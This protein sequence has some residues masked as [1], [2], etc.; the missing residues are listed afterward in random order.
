MKVLCENYAS[1]VGHPCLRFLVLR[2]LKEVEVSK[3]LQ[4]VFELGLIFEQLVLENVKSYFLINEVQKKFTCEELQLSGVV[5]AIVNN[6]LV[7]E[8]KSFSN[9]A[10]KVVRGIKDINR[11]YVYDRKLQMYYYQLQ[12]YFLLSGFDE[13]ILFCINRE[14][15]DER[16][17][18]IKQSQEVID[19]IVQKCKKVNSYVERSVEESKLVLPEALKLYDVCRSCSFMDVCR[20]EVVQEDIVFKKIHLSQDLQEKLDRYYVLQEQLKELKKL[21]KEIKDILKEFENGVYVLD[22]V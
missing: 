5:D 11:E 9:E 6:C 15:G 10:F 21:E 19:R 22:N 3:E 1:E 12:S 7:F 4:K 16:F 14:S 8:I 17:F 20:E 13:G 2:R 18:H